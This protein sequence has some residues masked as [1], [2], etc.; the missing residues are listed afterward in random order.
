[1]S[2]LLKTRAIVLKIL[3]YGDSSRIIQFFTEDFGKVSAILKGARSPKS[4]KGLMVDTFNLVQLI[5]YKKET[6]DIQ[7]VSEVDMINHFPFIKEDYDR[8][9]YANA[10]LEL[11]FN[12][13]V[14]NEHHHK[15]FIGSVRAFEL[16]NEQNQNPKLT[17]VKYF[18]F[19]VKEIG[20]EIQLQHC[21]I[22]NSEIE[23]AKHVRF[24][25]SAGA[26]CENCSANNFTD[27]ELNKE[28]FNLLICLSTKKNNIQYDEATL[29]KAIFLIEN[30]LKHNIHEF[31]GLKS[32]LS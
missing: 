6:R 16:L 30:F 5:M 10:V 25:Y 32:L 13:T 9:K 26:I 4:K 3:D 8:I 2:E 20:Y 28:L 21:S 22:C 12:L 14:E 23:E 19:F 24:N 27:T 29:D 11:L 31:K 17:F 1:M 7:L 15:M 18:L